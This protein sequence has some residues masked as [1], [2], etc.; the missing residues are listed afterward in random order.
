MFLFFFH[1]KKV[2]REKKVTSCFVSK[3][4][5]WIITKR[6]H[7]GQENEWVLSFEYVS[8]THLFKKS[9]LCK[10]IYISLLIF[11]GAFFN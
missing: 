7:L 11:A 8:K 1:E 3:N 4:R 6:E 2:P 10:F 5:W 9:R